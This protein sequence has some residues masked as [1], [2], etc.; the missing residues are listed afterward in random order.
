MMRM[1][2]NGRSISSNISHRMRGLAAVL[3]ALVPVV[4]II[5]TFLN[6]CSVAEGKAEPLI[7]RKAKMWTSQLKF[8]R[9]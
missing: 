5:V 9:R 7:A 1:V 6:R 3:V 2:P 8:R 4:R